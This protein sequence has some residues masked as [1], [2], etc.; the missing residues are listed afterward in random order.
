MPV[1]PGAVNP[2]WFSAD[3]KKLPS[4]VTECQA[5]R[6]FA[7]KKKKPTEYFFPNYQNY[8]NSQNNLKQ[9]VICSGD[10]FTHHH[11]KSTCA[12][13]PVL[14]HSCLHYLTVGRNNRD[15]LSSMCG[16]QA[17]FAILY[18][19]QREIFINFQLVR[20]ESH[21]KTFY[22]KIL[23]STTMKRQSVILSQFL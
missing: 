5:Y 4:K 17:F 19:L 12:S 6:G 22:M 16:P 14:A 13:I 1:L 18:I 21:L 3:R 9:L 2:L 11:I 10:N 20:Q 8:C 23:L 7:K 15:S